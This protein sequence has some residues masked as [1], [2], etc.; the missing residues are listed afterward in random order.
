VAI[1]LLNALLAQLV[2]HFHG[3][4]VRRLSPARANE[5]NQGSKRS[6]RD[7]LRDYRARRSVVCG[8]FRASLGTARSI[9]AVWNRTATGSLPRPVGRLRSRVCA[10]SWPLR[11]RCPPAVGRVRGPGLERGRNPRGW[12]ADGGAFAQRAR[13][14]LRMPTRVRRQ[15]YL[16][17][18]SIVIAGREVSP[19][20]GVWRGSSVRPTERQAGAVPRPKP[21]CTPRSAGGLREAA[22][23]RV[24]CWQILISTCGCESAPMSWRG[25][26]GVRQ[27]LYWE[28]RGRRAVIS[29]STDRRSS[30]SEDEKT[31]R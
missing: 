24:R 1:C 2:E 21:T 7:F 3:K 17:N 6:C 31:A 22:T 18:C 23:C 11:S 19:S 13:R 5:R 16:T 25:R 8:R 10:G 28:T 15:S 26:P 30:D 29:T 9:S 14:S 4:G 20:G 12:K 27:G